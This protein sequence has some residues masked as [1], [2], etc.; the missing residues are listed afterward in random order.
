MT[1]VALSNETLVAVAAYPGQT[2]TLGPTTA[3]ANEPGETLRVYGTGTATM[4]PGYWQGRGIFAGDY[5]GIYFDGDTKTNGVTTGVTYQR[6]DTADS[7]WITLA[8]HI[9][10]GTTITDPTPALGAPEY[11]AIS[12]TTLPSSTTGAV[13]VAEWVHGRDPI[14]VNTGPDYSVV[15]KAIGR[16]ANDAYAVEQGT[17]PAAGFDFPLAMVGDGETGTTSFTGT[18]VAPFIT[19]DG[20]TTRAGWREILRHRQVVCY[21]DC[22]GRKLYGLL[23]LAFAQDGP[24]ETVTITVDEV[25][26][27]EGVTS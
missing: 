9:E 25:W 13:T 5:S 17:F 21:R 19:D 18:I 16:H 1:T 8:E 11:R 4:G 12:H 26:H 27:R 3:T 14:F 15:G 7:P 20:V 6:R 2:L 10:P 24:V 23:S 22:Q